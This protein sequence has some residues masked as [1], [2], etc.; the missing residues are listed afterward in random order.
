ME[1]ILVALLPVSFLIFLGYLFK[2]IEF[3]S[4]EFWQYADKFTYYVLFP[5]LLVYKL[6]TASLNEIDGFAFISSSILTLIFITIFL[7]LLSK[8][9]FLFDG[10]AFTSIYQGAI[11]FNT[12]VFLALTDAIFGDSGLV[13]AA[14]L[15]T[16]MIPIINVF[17]ISI[18]SIY[19]ASSKI[20][21]ISFIKSIIKNPLILGCI[22]GGLLNYFGISLYAPIEKTLGILSSAALPLGLLSVG[23]GL[24]IKHIKEVKLELFS[25]LFTKLALFPTFIFFIGQAFGIQGQALA[26]LVLFG[27][28]PTASS[29]YILA[30]EL[31]GDLKL[32]STIIT[33][34]TLVSIFTIS[35]FLMLLQGYF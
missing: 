11:R 22:F 13:L 7:M 31:G 15:M 28:M 18:F 5:A 33:A 25:S 23:V 16:F 3:P 29:S 30:R 1:T 6:S 24:H 8:F 26:I 21:V 20:T 32:M 17:C 19:A 12:Y 2:R 10:K 14:L 35:A 27:S 4:I 34:E 9:L